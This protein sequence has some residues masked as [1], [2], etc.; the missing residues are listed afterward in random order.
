MYPHYPRKPVGLILSF[1]DL[2]NY[3]YKLMK[4][5]FVGSPR[6]I[7]IFISVDG[8]HFNPGL[9]RMKVLVLLIELQCMS[10][11]PDYPSFVM[12][13]R[14][15]HAS[16]I[17]DRPML[18]ALLVWKKDANATLPWWRLICGSFSIDFSPFWEK[19]DTLCSSV[20]IGG[21]L[22]WDRSLS[23]ILYVYTSS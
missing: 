15:S 12:Q 13:P 7:G 17:R 2:L 23:I 21:G 9:T 18:L 6:L 1:Q 16:W 3:C 11:P 10:L 8:E 22:L 20:I 14:L 19:M 5:T 4:I